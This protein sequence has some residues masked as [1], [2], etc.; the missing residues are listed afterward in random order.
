MD[1]AI[2]PNTKLHFFMQH[3]IH[4]KCDSGHEFTSDP[5]HFHPALRY[6]PGDIQRF[7]SLQSVSKKIILNDYL[8][9]VIPRDPGNGPTSAPGLPPVHLTPSKSCPYSGCRSTASQITCIYTSWPKFLH[10]SPPKEALSN[11]DGVSIHM[12]HTLKIPSVFGSNASDT[13]CVTYELVGRSVF[14]NGHFTS[15]LLIPQNGKLSTCHYNDMRGGKLEV[16]GDET[17][18][19]NDPIVGVED[20]YAYVRTSDIA[21]VRSDISAIKQAYFD[22]ET[23]WSKYF[24][25][26]Y[27]LT[28]EGAPTVP[29]SDPSFQRANPHYQLTNNHSMYVNT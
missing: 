10:I 20:F 14:Q 26:V 11:F 28:R 21:S 12:S 6:T 3:T 22:L 8:H 9:Y 2:T 24:R 29:K 13:P 17:V 4:W 16:H 19:D 23:A 18:I 5:A 25:P 7:L 1:S 27:D 15:D